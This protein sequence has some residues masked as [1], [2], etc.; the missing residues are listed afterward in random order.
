MPLTVMSLN[1]TGC[2]Q[3]WM[4]GSSAVGMVPVGR[5]SPHES[6]IVRAAMSTSPLLFAHCYERQAHAQCAREAGCKGGGAVELMPVGHCFP[7]ETNILCACSDG[8]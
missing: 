2:A 3:G 4:I 6:S 7:T 1:P 5:C 8:C